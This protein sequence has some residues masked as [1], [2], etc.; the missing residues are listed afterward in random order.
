M[1]KENKEE[2]FEHI[3][4][5]DALPSLNLDE[6]LLSHFQSGLPVPRDK[7]NRFFG[8]PETMSAEIVSFEDITKYSGLK[9]DLKEAFIN[10]A[11]IGGALID[12]DL[13]QILT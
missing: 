6:C 11:T 2:I 5:Y 7:I 9:N 3:K 12:D 1:V 4:E 8:K 13:T 10:L